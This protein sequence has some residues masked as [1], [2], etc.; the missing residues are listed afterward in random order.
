MGLAQGVVSKGVASTN[1]VLQVASVTRNN[2]INS[3]PCCHIVLPYCVVNK[4]FAM[5]PYC[6]V[7]KLFAMLCRA[8]YN[9]LKPPPMKQPCASHELYVDLYIWSLLCYTIL[10]YTILWY[11]ILYHNRISIYKSYLSLS[12]YTYIYRYMYMYMYVYIY[13]HYTIL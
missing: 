8:K 6:V 1:L 7:N 4:L 2:N 3:L 11:N 10:Y 13:T 5:L 12:L 9:I